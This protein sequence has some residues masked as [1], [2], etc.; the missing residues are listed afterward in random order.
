MTEIQN[1]NDIFQ[2]RL[3]FHDWRG[4][5]EGVNASDFEGKPE[6]RLAIDLRIDSA[7][8]SPPW[9]FSHAPEEPHK[10]FS[11]HPLSIAGRGDPRAKGMDR[12]GLPAA[13][14]FWWRNGVLKNSILD[15]SA[16][17]E[18]LIEC[19]APP[20]GRRRSHSSSIPFA[21]GSPPSAMDHGWGEDCLFG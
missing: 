9:R 16:K 11:P 7:S 14:C 12:F 13:A 8:R 3:I 10:Q 15:F 19:I 21:L 20:K 1:S 17:T 18:E 2:C 6:D 4:C 5:T